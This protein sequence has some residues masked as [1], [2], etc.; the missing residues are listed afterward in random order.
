MYEMAKNQDVQKVLQDEID[1]YFPDDD[2]TVE[3]DNVMKMEYLD[4]VWNETLRKYPLA[5][6]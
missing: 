5:S 3:Y 6:T 2:D 1:K 4:M